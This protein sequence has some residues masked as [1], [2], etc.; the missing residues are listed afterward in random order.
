MIDISPGDLILH[1]GYTF[2]TTGEVRDKFYL[3]VD[4]DESCD[5]V[6]AYLTTTVAK[7]YRDISGSPGCY[8]AHLFAPCFLIDHKS[9]DH[10]F[11]K[12]T[13]IQFN[14]CPSVGLNELKLLMKE[15]KAARVCTYKDEVF[16]QIVKCAY[17]AKTIERI[18]KKRI[19]T[20]K[21]KL[22]FKLYS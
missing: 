12:E 5:S 19:K 3:I 17:N 2:P 8:N 18:F 10:Y 22:A 11:E 20:L 1:K 6:Y 13:F 4:I 15:G 21:E 16:F 9:P 14:N 7:N